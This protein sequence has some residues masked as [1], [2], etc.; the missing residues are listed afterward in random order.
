MLAD[1]I[2]SG[3]AFY[4][5]EG[6]ARKSCLPPVK[7]WCCKNGMI[8]SSPKA[9][10]DADQGLFIKTASKAKARRICLKIEGHCCIEGQVAQMAAGVCNEKKGD[11][12]G[13]DLKAAEKYCRSLK[14]WCCTKADYFAATAGA[15]TDKKG[16]FSMEKSDAQ[17]CFFSQKVYCCQEEKVAFITMGACYKGK[18]RHFRHKNKAITAC[19]Q[20]SP[21][22][23]MAK[24]LKVQ[25]P[26]KSVKPAKKAQ[27]AG[28]KPMKVHKPLLKVDGKAP[29]PAPPATQQMGQIAAAQGIR[30]KGG[31]IPKDIRAGLEITRPFAGSEVHPG[32]E[33]RIG[34][35][36][37]NPYRGSD[38][39]GATRVRV[40]HYTPSGVDSFSTEPVFEGSFRPYVRHYY[41]EIPTD[42]LS[43]EYYVRVD[44]G[45]WVT[46]GISPYAF[47]ESDPF[48]IV[49]ADDLV[50]TF[51][52]ARSPTEPVLWL[53]KHYTIAWNVYGRLRDRNGYI[54]LLKDG[55]SLGELANL[56]AAQVRRERRD[57][58]IP[59]PCH[60]DYRIEPGGNYHIL[61]VLIGEPSLNF[62]SRTFS[63][64]MPEIRL[65][66]A[67]PARGERWYIDNM[68]DIRWTAEG[69]EPGVTVQLALMRGDNI[70]MTIARNVPVHEGRYTWRVGRDVGGP[71]GGNFSRDN[72]GGPGPPPEADDYSIGIFV[73]D[74]REIH[75]QGYPF[76]LRD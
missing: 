69:F 44:M 26:L 64:R 35:R 42:I 38:P 76:S 58:H 2:N 73:T 46:D 71:L 13:K 9:A 25:K 23:V 5:N 40:Y 6:I 41:W 10:C 61:F 43:G 60:E 11:F 47:G 31:G 56:N 34:W 36:L 28:I 16:R 65:D 57:W 3:G 75:A 68:E 37:L 70:W 17:A 51:P 54:V 63:L 8:E 33:T 21:K 32:N 7:G 18:G 15:C 24:N 12:F 29:R 74:C 62:R 67:A 19:R 53:G 20:K 22:S 50:L 4:E 49:S 45:P 48:T 14:G 1:C 52:P 30:P 66:P 72:M 27:A 55:R 39:S 59:R